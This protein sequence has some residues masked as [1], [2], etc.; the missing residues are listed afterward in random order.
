M[1]S[2]RSTSLSDDDRK[3]NTRSKGGGKS[4]PWHGGKNSLHSSTKT[5]AK[6]T[7]KDNRNESAKTMSKGLTSKKVLSSKM[8]CES[9]NEKSKCK[10]SITPEAKDVESEVPAEDQSLLLPNSEVH[11]DDKQ[12][13]TTI[14]PPLNKTFPDLSAQK[15]ITKD[16]SDSSDIPVSLLLDSKMSPSKEINH[17]NGSVFQEKSTHLISFSEKCNTSGI[18]ATKETTSLQSSDKLLGEGSRPSSSLYTLSNQMNEQLEPTTDCVNEHLS[19]SAGEVHNEVA[20]SNQTISNKKNNKVCDNNPATA[21][22]LNKST[23]NNELAQESSDG[24]TVRKSGRRSIPNRKYLDMETDFSS[25]KSKST[26]PTEKKPPKSPQ[27]TKTSKAAQNS[28]AS[29][30]KRKLDLTPEKIPDKKYK[31]Q[32]EEPVDKSPVKQHKT[33]KP[34]PPNSPT[35]SKKPEPQQNVISSLGN[36][37]KTPSS[38]VP[39]LDSPTQISLDNTPVMSVL[40]DANEKVSNAMVQNIVQS[41]SPCQME[42]V[43]DLIM[44]TSTTTP[45]QSLQEEVQLTITA[46]AETPCA[47]IGTNSLESFNVA[48]DN[49]DSLLSKEISENIQIFQNIQKDAKLKEDQIQMTLPSQMEESIP[50]EMQ[51]EKSISKSLDKSDSKADHVIIVQ[52]EQQL[53]QSSEFFIGEKELIQK[54]LCETSVNNELNSV[55]QFSSI[56]TVALQN[57][58]PSSVVEP[59]YDVEVSLPSAKPIITFAEQLPHTSPYT[60]SLLNNSSKDKEAVESLMNETSISEK[61]LETPNVMMCL[62]SGGAELVSGSM[63]LDVATHDDAQRLETEAAIQ[64]ITAS[65]TQTFNGNDIVVTSEKDTIPK[66]SLSLA[67]AAKMV[68]E[69][70]TIV[71]LQEEVTLP[72]N[73]L[74]HCTVQQISE[75]TS[76]IASNNSN[77]VPPTAV[78]STQ[79]PLQL[80]RKGVNSAKV[81]SIIKSLP[82]NA[83]SH[84]KLN[85]KL[86]VEDECNDDEEDEEEE[87]EEDEEDDEEE[88]EGIDAAE[89]PNQKL[90]QEFI[91]VHLPEGTQIKRQR[92]DHRSKEEGLVGVRVDVNGCYKCTECDY[93]TVKKVNWYKH[94]KKHLGLRPHSCI[95]CNYKATTSS[96]LKRHMAIHADLREYKCNQCSHYFRQKIH[97]ERHMKYKH[98]EK[99]I[100]CPLCT[101][102]CANEN[103]D[104]KIH[105][106]RRHVTSESTDGAMQAFTCGECGLVTMSKKDLKQHAKFH[107]KGPELKLFC[108]QCSFVTDCESRLRR[109]VLTHTKVKPF[110]CG[111][112]EY[113]GSQKEHVL[114]HMKSRHSIDIQRNPRRQRE[115]E[116]GMENLERDKGDFTSRDKIFACNHCTMKFSKLINLYKHL[117]TQHKT[118]MPSGGQN[119]FY[120]VVCDFKTI[121]KKNLLVHMR[122]HN[123]QEQNPPSH[124]YSCVLCRYVNPKRRNL[125]QHMMK[126][127]GI[128]IVMNMKDDWSSS[129]F[130]DNN[131]PTVHDKGETNE[132]QVMTVNNNVVTTSSD[133]CNQL[134]VVTDDGGSNPVQTVITIEDLASSMTKPV[135]MT[136]VTLP[137]ETEEL[138]HKQLTDDLTQ[139]QHAA[140]AVEG[141]QALAEQPGIVEPESHSQSD[142]NEDDI[143]L[144]DEDIKTE[145]VETEDMCNPSPIAADAPALVLNQLPDDGE[146]KDSVEL[147]SDQIVH[148]SPGDYVEINGELYKVEISTEPAEETVTTTGDNGLEAVPVTAAVSELFGALPNYDT[149]VTVPPASST[150]TFVA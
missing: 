42:K 30:M 74:T 2:T 78:A 63:A 95:K 5:P 120:C 80:P 98:E 145:S 7:S 60:V 21:T 147:T 81:G 135:K 33:P 69:S 17:I 119:E 126:K 127:H 32:A 137:P 109:H 107:R 114:R 28:G 144:D 68:A 71:D 53:D 111:L 18:L 73:S 43:S 44:T 47:T 103:P 86:D 76:S 13:N 55:D 35:V 1:P 117:H 102:V 138:S 8:N 82:L 99:K 141:L 29:L 116:N 24:I 148:L 118:I 4:S 125:F 61:V 15:T 93:C 11:S 96:N 14:D 41:F 3:P 27:T 84:S 87:E 136:Q 134:M 6:A 39:T 70:Q 65:F 34:P 146:V 57:S 91:I 77:G 100:R 83:S 50:E 62:S 12:Q 112:C 25:R 46:E 140:D 88:E 85:D 20:N 124:V 52:Q 36:S 139:Q 10:V 90:T 123:M 51:H 133:D 79:T 40:K 132:P 121:N 113:R 31:L 64:E 142:D 67:E 104:L 94:R 37:V 54:D 115:D 19:D 9:S 101:Y 105:I 48:T 16:N 106:K 92:V 130:I 66:S 22:K 129:C 131:V 149:T 58:I 45:E 75:T 38:S 26:T 143:I 97:L 128:E 122:K 56:P 89:V 108:E 72:I 59:S 49:S 110:K 23:N 150:S